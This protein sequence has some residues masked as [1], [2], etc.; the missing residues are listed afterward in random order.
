MS[1]NIV[2]RFAPSPT[3]YAHVG[4]ARTAIF[5]YLFAKRYGGKAI[6]RFED[7][8]KERS[9]KE[10]EEDI[11]H[12][13]EWLGISFDA[14][15]KQSER[16]AVYKKYLEKMIDA[17]AAY[18]SKE[19]VFIE[20]AVEE[21]VGDVK[22]IKGEKRSEVIRFKNPNSVV[23]FNDVILGDISVDTSELKDF[24]IA[25]SLEEPLY[26]LAVVIDDFEMSVS[27]VIRG[28]DGIYNTPRQILIQEAIGAP[29][30]IYCHIPFVLGADK[31]KLSKRNGS[32]P[33]FDYRKEGFLPE[34]LINYMALLGFNPG[35]SKEIFSLEELIGIFD[36]EKVQKSGAVFDIEKFKWFNREHIKDL[37]LEDLKKNIL[38]FMPDYVRDLPQWSE[39]RFNSILP[40]IRERISVFSDVREMSEA[41][42]FDYIFDKPVFEIADILPPSKKDVESDSKKIEKHL[43]FIINSIRDVSEGAFTKDSVKNILWDYASEHGRG[44][45]LWPMR[46]A[47]SGKIK[48]LDPFTLCSILGKKEILERL[49]SA[50]TRLHRFNE[51]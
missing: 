36:L 33:I 29:R 24:V 46:F 10:F 51:Q 34:A 50:Q 11:F 25:K 1:S 9:K 2:T 41:G 42:E 21:D 30:P 40:E 12:A 6:L 38:L 14:I 8:D 18:I 4:V 7:T 27:H 16:G 13:M 31:A 19:D 49:E 15:Y 37:S 48:S 17:G 3:G 32:V 26:H 43:S 47:L 44:D 22:D 35:G 28:V 5:N 20:D 23:S 39:D 45:V